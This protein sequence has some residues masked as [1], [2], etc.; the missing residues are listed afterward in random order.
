MPPCRDS[1][2]NFYLIFV[3]MCSARAWCL[4][5]ILFYTLLTVDIE[6][7]ADHVKRRFFQQ[8]YI[9]AC[10]KQSKRSKKVVEFPT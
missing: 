10:A 6:K 9:N 5:H 3:Y 4:C 1:A 7:Q 8:Y 2:M